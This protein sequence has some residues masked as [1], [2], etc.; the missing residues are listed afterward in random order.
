MLDISVDDTLVFI[1]KSVRAFYHD[2]GIDIINVSDARQV[3]LM[4]VEWIMTLQPVLTKVFIMVIKT[5][6]FNDTVTI[7]KC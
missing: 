2:P 7:D 1:V 4:F 6:V 3:V 5:G